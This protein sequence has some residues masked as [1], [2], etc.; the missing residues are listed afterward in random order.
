MLCPPDI[1]YVYRWVSGL[2][3]HCIRAHA[4]YYSRRSG[5]RPLGADEIQ[6]YKEKR[7][8]GSPHPSKTPSRSPGGVD[9]VWMSPSTVVASRIVRVLPVLP[10]LPP[11]PPVEAE[12]DTQIGVESAESGQ[13]AVVD[14]N[15]HAISS[16]LRMYVDVSSDNESDLGSI[17]PELLIQSASELDLYLADP[18]VAV[19]GM[20]RAPSDECMEH[21]L[22]LNSAANPAPLVL[23][24][25]PVDDA[26]VPQ[27]VVEAALSPNFTN[28]RQ[29]TMSLLSTTRSTMSESALLFALECARLAVET[30]RD[31]L[32][33]A[34]SR[35]VMGP[36]DPSIVLA[37]V[38]A[39]L[40][41][42][43]E[44]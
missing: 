37:E 26:L 2:N 16:C 1:T 12:L 40:F 7:A 17:S 22:M 9:Q 44:S 25:S 32:R 13:S 24:D 18:Q 3:R 39:L 43:T 42:D 28:A 41:S 15:S 6:R 29:T 10:Y 11:P 8:R 19:L 4:H 38:E 14:D 31:Q 36:A 30:T 20:E 21:G 34:L 33:Q 35:A 5:Y 27:R 23:S